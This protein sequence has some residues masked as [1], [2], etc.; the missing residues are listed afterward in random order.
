MIFI[1]PFLILLFAG[2]VLMIISERAITKSIRKELARYNCKLTSIDDTD[3]EFTLPDA[4]PVPFFRVVYVWYGNAPAR[5]IP[6][7]REICFTTADNKTIKCLV[8]IK[9]KFLSPYKL[10]FQ[11]DLNKL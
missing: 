5:T 11:V 4:T 2:I 9:S 8:A 7:F 6:T 10:Y 3:E 1:I